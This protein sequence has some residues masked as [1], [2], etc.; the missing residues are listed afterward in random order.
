M[1]GENRSSQAL[2]AAQ[3]RDPQVHKLID[4]VEHG[5]LPDDE[6]LA[7]KLALQQ[8]LFTVVDGVLYYVDPKRNNCKRAVVPQ[9]L[10]E[11]ILTQTH[12]GP[13]GGHFS[14]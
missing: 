13:F 3:A 9:S 2:A 5:E 11:Q 8:S 7:R 12:S 4:L 1:D 14:G 10:K 6:T